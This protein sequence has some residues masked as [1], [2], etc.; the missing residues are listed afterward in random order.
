MPECLIDGKLNES[1]HWWEFIK[2]P[3]DIESKPFQ[4]PLYDFSAPAIAFSTPAVGLFSSCCQPVQ[5]PLSPPLCIDLFERRF[6]PW[7]G[8]DPGDQTAAPGRATMAASYRHHSKITATIR[9]SDGCSMASYRHHSKIT[10]TVGK[11]GGCSM[12]SYRHHSRISATIRKSGS[13]SMANY[14]HHSKITAIIRKSGGCSMASY[15]TIRK[16]PPPF[17]KTV[18]KS[19]CFHLCVNLYRN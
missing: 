14:R 2:P 17:E 5:L 18:F 4:L 8:W 6:A 13:C 16:S 1:S 3:I 7:C 9:K 19:Y 10:A 15:R 12:V 11:S